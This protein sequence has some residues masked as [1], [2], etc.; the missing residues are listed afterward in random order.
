MYICVCG[1]F[2]LS[3][4]QTNS[5]FWGALTIFSRVLKR[6][7][8]QMQQTSCKWVCSVSDGLHNKR[9]RVLRRAVVRMRSRTVS[10]ALLLLRPAECDL[11]LLTQVSRRHKSKDTGGFYP[12][13]RLRYS[14]FALSWRVMWILLFGPPAFVANFNSSAFLFE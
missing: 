6:N 4:E 8:N 7:A 2:L 9:L 3:W 1:S 10:I 12:C 11:Q 5:Y 13:L 14:S